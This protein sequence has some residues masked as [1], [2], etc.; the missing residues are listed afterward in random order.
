MRFSIA[1]TDCTQELHCRIRHQAEP[2]GQHKTAAAGISEDAVHPI[3]LV[4]CFIYPAYGLHRLCI[5]SARNTSVIIACTHERCAVAFFSIC[6]ITTT[7]SFGARLCS[8]CSLTGAHTVITL[9]PSAVISAFSIPVSDQIQDRSHL[10]FM[11]RDSPRHMC[12]IRRPLPYVI[13]R[14]C[15]VPADEIEFLVLPRRIRRYHA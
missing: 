6:R 15:A 8:A 7:G 1:A 12:M 14:S 3:F 2:G 13:L 5:I 10:F 4:P 9:F 11:Q